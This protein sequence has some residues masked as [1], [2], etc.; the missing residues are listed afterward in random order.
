MRRGDETVSGPIGMCHF[1]AA[2][3]KAGTG[4]R[5]WGEN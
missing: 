1:G 4:K 3:R 5:K 2:E